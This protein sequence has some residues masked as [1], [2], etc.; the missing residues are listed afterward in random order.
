[1]GSS[2]KLEKLAYEDRISNLP[3]PILTHIL[4]F[5]P[6]KS[7]VGT[8]V[9]SKRWK[10]PFMSLP[11]LDFNDSVSIYRDMFGWDSRQKVSFMN[12]VD[13]ILMLRGNDLNLERFS[14]NCVGNY[15]LSRVDEWIRI[16]VGHNVKE[17]NLTL[18]FR[19]VYKL[20]EDV[21]MCTSIEVFRLKWKI[22]VNVPENVGFVSLKFLQ[23]TGV[24]FASYESVEKLLQCC[25]VL[26][27]LVIE[28][29]KWLSGCCLSVCGSALKNFSL[30]SYSYLD[31]EVEL[32]ILIDT[33]ALET[34]DIRELTSEGIFIKENMLSITTASIDVAQKVERSVP[35][36]VYGDS[37]F[38]LLKKISHV[39]YLTL[40]QSTLGALSYA[41]DFSFPTFHDLSH[42]E[43]I[44]DAWSGWTLLPSI[45]GSA[46]NLETLVFPQGLVDKFSSQS[47]FFRFSWSPP[48][49][50]P[51][52]LSSKLKSIEIKNFQGI[53][54]EFSLVKY[55]LKHGRVLEMMSI[56]CSLLA[57]DAKIQKKLYKFRRASSTCKLFL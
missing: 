8:T 14:L 47:Q 43:L 53:N 36:S 29:C 27:D 37:V 54:D 56:D 23:F 11:N 10:S 28:N 44:V 45:L 30:D 33:P 4:S 41:S 5:L 39:K 51:D 19:E 21:Y 32:T 16:V 42:L 18:N 26:E 57:D 20:V 1:M 2:S 46:P 25:P 38:G 15:H 40:C 7:A 48:D 55:L 17:I 6:T 24:K 50:V 49:R 13:R 12:F 3:D 52:C 31:T 22:L 9:L 35:S 34:L